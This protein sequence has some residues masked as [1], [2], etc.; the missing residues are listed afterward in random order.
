MVGQDVKENEMQIVA[1]AAL[2]RCLDA[3]GNSKVIEPSMIIPYALKTNF[4]VADLNNI[5]INGIIG[6]GIGTTENIPSNYG[7]VFQLS[8]QDN[9]RAGFMNNW[10]FQFAFPTDKATFYY[11]SVINDDNWSAWKSVS[12]T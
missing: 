7:I 8:N 5:N 4:M 9:P 1:V 2:L 3:A 10:V 11:R 6:Y 12:F